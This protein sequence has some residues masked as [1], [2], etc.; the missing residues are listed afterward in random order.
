MIGAKDFEIDLKSIEEIERGLVYEPRV[1]T[2]N[3]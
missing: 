3:L 2:S 1:Y